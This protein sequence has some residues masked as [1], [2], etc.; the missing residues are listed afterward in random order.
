MKSDKSNKNYLCESVV[1][2]FS[3]F[4]EP[5]KKLCL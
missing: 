1:K 4:C 3:R 5:N 2:Y